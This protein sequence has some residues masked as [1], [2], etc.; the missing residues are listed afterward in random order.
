MPSMRL[1]AAEY[2]TRCAR[3]TS[4]PR[5]RPVRRVLRGCRSSCRSGTPGG[6][7]STSA[8][9]FRLCP[10]ARWL[11]GAATSCS[12]LP[13]HGSAFRRGRGVRRGPART[14]AG[15]AVRSKRTVGAALRPETVD[16]ERGSIITRLVWTT[17][18]GH[19]VEG[20]M[21]PSARPGPS[22][23]EA[24]PAGGDQPDPACSAI[25][26]TGSRSP[27]VHDATELTS[28]ELV[29]LLTR[30]AFPNDESGLSAT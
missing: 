11:S 5:A 6:R 15:A 12:D 24:E 9:P 20:M 17:R 2:Y 3:W 27:A 8:A 21:R 13:L 23:G 29:A 30:S 28:R 26:R 18:L 10:R 22:V 25:R 7:L 4:C 14:P 19:E 1:T 16:Q